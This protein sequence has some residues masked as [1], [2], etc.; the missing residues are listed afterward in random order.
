M[1]TRISIFDT[2]ALGVSGS[3]PLLSPFA[4]SSIC[5]SSFVTRLGDDAAVLFPGGRCFV[6]VAR[7]DYQRIIRPI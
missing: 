3:I 1:S 2:D 7:H 6:F 4:R 5:C